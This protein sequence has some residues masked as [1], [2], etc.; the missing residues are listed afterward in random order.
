MSC[1]NCQ[2]SRLACLLVDSWTAYNMVLNQ[3]Y[4]RVKVFTNNKYMRTFAFFF[5][6]RP[7]TREILITVF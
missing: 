1:K 7:T 3:F 6:F 5:K 4:F 2:R